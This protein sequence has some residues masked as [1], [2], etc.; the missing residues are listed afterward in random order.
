MSPTL[1]LA[2]GT[3]CVAES[4]NDTDCDAELLRDCDGESDA[5]PLSDTVALSDTDADEELDV[6]TVSD[7]LY[8]SETVGVGGGVMVVVIEFE[9]LLTSDSVAADIVFD[10]DTENVYDNVG[11]GGGVIV[12]EMEF[13]KLIS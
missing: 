11:V 6:E 3:C 10:A 9:K 12:V 5:E 13:E 7:M 4:E 1:V 8:E 2:V